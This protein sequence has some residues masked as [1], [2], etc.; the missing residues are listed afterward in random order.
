LIPE[1]YEYDDS[2]LVN[3]QKLDLGLRQNGKRV[4]DVK[5]PKWAKDSKDFLRINRQA[6][7]S[8]YVS[9]NLHHWI[10]LIFGYKQQGEEAVK[11]DNVFHYLTYE[12][13]VNLDAIMDPVEKNALKLQ[14]NEFGQTPKQIFKIPHP[15]RHD[16]KVHIYNPPKNNSAVK[17]LPK[18]NV[19]KDLEETEDF[20]IVDSS[21]VK[22]TV[23]IP[24][25]NLS[26]YQEEEAHE[27]RRIRDEDEEEEVYGEI[28]KAVDSKK[29][30]EDSLWEAKGMGKLQ[31]Q[32][33]PKVHKSQVSGLW[34]LPDK[35]V[36]SIGHDG[37]IKIT[38]FQSMSVSRSF[39]VCDL[40]LSSVA[41]L[42]KNEL[43][44]LGSWDN[45]LYIFNLNYGTKVFS[46][47]LH[48]DAISY[49]TFDPIKSTLYTTS[50]DCTVRSWGYK[51]GQID[52][53][54]SQIIAE[55]NS[56]ISKMKLSSDGNLLLYGDL[57]GYVHLHD[58]RKQQGITSFL[59]G[60]EKITAM[61]FLSNKQIVVSGETYI[62]LVD[63]SGNEI[64]HIP[65]DHRLGMITDM[66]KEGTNLIISTDRGNAS[67]FSVLQEKRIGAFCHE[68]GLKDGEITPDYEF[69]CLK[70]M[71]EGRIGV[72]GS[73]SGSITF[74]YYPDMK[75]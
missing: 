66:E 34:E 18:D 46:E 65:I 47:P 44:A 32:Q 41:E 25:D 62:K 49:I 30:G 63:M 59:V 10:D 69:T 4:N 16:F 70:V 26:D 6:L 2:F 52:T 64:L 23:E 38:Q 21:K 43:Y 29:T 7:E 40:S 36:L 15:P 42:K 33:V 19:L 55:T 12:G 74:N 71:S 3:Y 45:N 35:R 54:Y 28:L 9:E 27:E 37:F 51:S 50:W 60:N 68:N 13:A 56:Q 58:L 17:Y 14:I 39:K 1:F 73:Q 31:M 11:A 48:E 53:N 72:M 75:N 20:E 61:H 67:I 8:N 5:L 24:K 57:E 22:N